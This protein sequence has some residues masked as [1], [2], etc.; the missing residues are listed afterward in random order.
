MAMNQKERIARNP[1]LLF[2]GRALVETKTLSAVLVL[3]YL[4]RGLELGE[5]FF[6]SI[7]W[8]LTSLATEVPSGY[9]ADLIGRKRTLLLGVFL[10]FC[11]QVVTLFA[12]GFWPFVGVFILMSASFSCFSGTEEAML[13]ESLEESGKSHEMNARN[14]KLLSARSFPDILVP[15]IGAFI[16]RDLA[17]DQFRFLILLNTVAAFAAFAILACLV[18]PTRT[19]SVV[20]KECG[21]FVQSIRT[22]TTQPW[23]LKV[24]CNK[25]LVFVAVFVTWRV[26]QPF[27]TAHGFSIEALGVFYVVFQGLDFVG[28][29]FAG[30][31]E[32]SLGT[33]RTIT[34]I[35][36][37]MIGTLVIAVFS[38]YPIVVFVALAFSLSM[39]SLRDAMFSHAI[40][41]RIASRSRATTLSNLNVIK[42]ILD[43]PVLLLAGWLSILSLD[44]PLA[45][46]AVL[47]LVVLVFLPIRKTELISK[48]SP[49]SSASCV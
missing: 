9:L 44:F 46:A 23:L 15:A 7:V 40:N 18:E 41:C 42:G 30:K 38:G 25:I 48:V 16:A 2:L 3:F 22:I 47:C 39:N 13:F 5:I 21:I 12:W 28:G 34:L 10:L 6:L 19:Q 20:E 45:L 1:R 49:A 8:S 14:G 4:H 17:E 32:R 29:W 33:V 31:I 24:A 43:I 36:V 11:S 26:T 27:L 37:V 35:P